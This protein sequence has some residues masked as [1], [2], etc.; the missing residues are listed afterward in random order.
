LPVTLGLQRAAFLT[1]P[2]ML[3]LMAGGAALGALGGLLARGRT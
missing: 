2:Q 1:F 3:L